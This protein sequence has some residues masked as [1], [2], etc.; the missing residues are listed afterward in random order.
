FSRDWSS[1]VC[2]SDL[3]LIE[4]VRY[5]DQPEVKA[6]L[7]QAIDN[8]ADQ[9]RIRELI[10]AYSLARDRLDT[11]KVRQIRQEFERAQA[12]RLQPHFEIGRASCRG[13]GEIA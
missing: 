1:D 3:L 4:A 11:T 6:R 10:E 2:S 8:L 13:R 12:R 7:D 5:G 9:K